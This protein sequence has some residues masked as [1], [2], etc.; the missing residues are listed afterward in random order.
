MVSQRRACSCALVC[1]IGTGIVDA[2]AS[3][4]VDSNSG[5]VR[6]VR[7][8][9]KTTVLEPRLQKTRTTTAKTNTA[10]AALTDPRHTTTNTDPNRT[11]PMIEQK[12]KAASAATK[13]ARPH[14]FTNM[15]RTDEIKQKAVTQKQAP[16]HRCEAHE[17]SETVLTRYGSTQITIMPSPAADRADQNGRF[18]DDVRGWPATGS[19]GRGGS[20]PRKGTQ[21]YPLYPSEGT[22][23]DCRLHDLL[24]RPWAFT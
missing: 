22:V 16:A 6:A 10:N 2:R 4:E 18:R 15:T 17:M 19:T 24:K 20:Q 13:P 1:G 23:L 5:R 12:R 9:T 8:K 7:G 21:H 3:K 11:T 14:I